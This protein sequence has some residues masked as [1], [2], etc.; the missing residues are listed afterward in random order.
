MPFTGLV[1]QD[2][3]VMNSPPDS[4]IS[5]GLA[6]SDSL[7]HVGLK[8]Q[9][10]QIKQLDS[11]KKADS[12]HMVGLQ[13]ELENLKNAETKRKKAIMEEMRKLAETDSLN[14]LKKVKQIE[15][16]RGKFKGVPVLLDEDTLFSVYGRSGP[17]LPQERALIL[18]KRI[19]KMAKAQ[20]YFPDSLYVFTESD[21]TLILYQSSIV[22]SVTE[23]DGLFLQANTEAVANNWVKII[24]QKVVS[25]RER[26]GLKRILREVG[27]SVL[28]IVILIT[29]IWLI[30]R[31]FFWLY[32][33]IHGLKGSMLKG[34]SLRSY[35]LLDQHRETEL[36]I[37]M[38]KGLRLIILILTFYLALPAIFTIFPETQKYAD[39]LLGYILSPISV[40]V[41]SFIGYIPN[42]FTILVIYLFT[43]YVVKF[44]HFISGEIETGKLEISGFYPDWARPTFNIL[45]ALLYI[46]M[47]IIIFPY[48]P[49]SHSPIFQGVSVFLGLL[50]SLGSSSA[51]SNMVA[52][53][54]ITYM[55]PFKNGDRIKIGDLIGDVV[56]R[57]LLVTRI[58]TPKNEEI[59][60]PNAQIL[61]AATVNYSTQPNYMLDTV[62]TIG[63]DVPWRQVEELLIKAAK[64]TGGILDEPAPF[65]LQTSLDD[66]YVSYKL[67]AYTNLVK[68]LPRIYSELH[69]RI[70]DEFNAGKVEILSP[71]Y[72]ALRDGNMI[73][74]PAS[75]LPDDYKIPVFGVKVSE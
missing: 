31:F 29:M 75:Y 33:K 15:Q 43:F 9:L 14:R 69:S 10:A 2:S 72:R 44:F 57:N 64:S 63:Y 52:G 26:H 61:G 13:A 62:V 27:F 5:E 34:I 17:F 4:V 66:F 18:S 70:Q 68:T 54:V 38:A 55:R 42:V 67:N 3:T 49:G 73:T 22:L 50:I 32:K 65:V 35:Q 30:N 16:L 24:N 20:D 23:E 6:P 45:R 51:I 59:T 60:L 53:V 36:V 28:V 41:Q 71:H 74:I 19:D 58:K 12:L 56:E 46:F 47:F 25:Y 21:A 37:F 1:A 8:L 11:L 39:L 40:I 7:L 48:L